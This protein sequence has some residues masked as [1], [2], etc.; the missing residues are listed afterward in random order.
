MVHAASWPTRLVVAEV[1]VPTL[2]MFLAV[3]FDV[4]AALLVGRAARAAA[5]QYYVARA[6]R[7]RALLIGLCA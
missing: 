7:L 1:V 5:A 3:V 6:A 2:L 4:P